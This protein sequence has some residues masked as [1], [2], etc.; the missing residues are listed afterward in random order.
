MIKSILNNLKFIYRDFLWRK[1][2]VTNNHETAKKFYDDHYQSWPINSKLILYE[3]QDGK[4]LDDSPFAILREWISLDQQMEH[5]IVVRETA[6]DKVNRVLE[7]WGLQKHE[8]IHVLIY[9]SYEHLKQLLCA[10]YIITNAMIF[11]DIFVKRPGQIFINTWHGTPLKRMGYAMPG[12][13]MGSW[14]VIRNLLMTNYLVLPNDYTAGI[15]KKDYRLENLYSGSILLQGYP[16]NDILVNGLP[17]KQSQELKVDLDLNSRK[18]LILYAPTWSGDATIIQDSEQE[19]NRYLSILDSLSQI[20][21]TITIFKPHPYFEATVNSDKR[22][23]AYNIPN[24][25]GTN[26]ILSEVDMLI[27]DYSSLFFDYLVTGK[28]IIFFDAKENYQEERGTYIDVNELPGPYTKKMEELVELVKSESVWRNQYTDRYET[29][30]KK[31]VS[32]DDG[33]ATQRVINTIQ[34]S[35]D[36]TAFV[37]ETVLVNGEDFSEKNFSESNRELVQ[38]IATSYDVSLAIF[39]AHVLDYWYGYQFFNNIDNV[40]ASTRVFVNK[41]ATTKK[42][43]QSSALING[44]RIT[45]GQQFGILVIP[46]K[47]FSIHQKEITTTAKTI[48]MVKNPTRELWLSKIGFVRYLENNDFEIWAKGSYRDVHFAKNIMKMLE[49]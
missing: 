29:F 16:R 24:K 34:K 5:V 41:N 45:G 15:F 3:M 13:V 49:K 22:F 1:E 12:G 32:Q 39:E 35:S 21:D 27:T 46:Q 7:Y 14:N 28:P 6:I 47:H 43:N 30:R 40:M 23:K 10:K 9:E 44:S 31:F 11:S 38:R 18:R 37:G 33:M 4:E 48:I 17:Q 2:R 26:V 25:F 8:S 42:L 20:S 19:I 36:D